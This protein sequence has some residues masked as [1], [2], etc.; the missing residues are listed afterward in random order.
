MEVDELYTQILGIDEPWSIA[1]VELYEKQSLVR[2][3]LEHA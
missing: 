3:Q 2:V 1:D